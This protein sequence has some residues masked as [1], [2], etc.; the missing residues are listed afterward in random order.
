MNL[1]KA[2]S[3]SFLFIFFSIKLVAQTYTEYLQQGKIH[4]SNL[5]YP[6]AYERFSLAYE[7]AKTDIERKDAETFKNASFKFLQKQYK[8]MEQNLRSKDTIIKKLN[9]TMAKIFFYENRFCVAFQN[10]KFGFIDRNG[11]TV[12]PYIYD[13]AQPFDIFSGFAIVNRNNTRY[14]IDTTGTEYLLSENPAAVN[15]ETLALDL[16]N[17][18]LVAIP[19]QVFA[20]VNLKILLLGNNNIESVPDQIIKLQNLNKLDLSNNKIS[21]LPEDF[22]K[23]NKMKSLSLYGNQIGKLPESFSQLKM[24]Q[25]LNLEN[26]NLF[27][28]PAGIGELNNLIYLNLSDNKLT[29]IPDEMGKLDKLLTFSVRRNN[30]EKLPESIGNL[31]NIENLYLDENNIIDLPISF[32]NLRSLKILDISRNKIGNIPYELK[33]MEWLKEFNLRGNNIPEDKKG[34]IKSWFPNCNIQI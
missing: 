34:M 23:L 28:L 8:E 20:C 7:L 15:L 21:K 25:E 11:N 31:D 32:S 24:L 5:N 18:D 6:S 3:V 22:G 1:L 14:L 9:H 33:K 29:K 26:N 27:I 12:L 10:G 30:I 13:E 2:N 4:L 16:R 19:S 17:K